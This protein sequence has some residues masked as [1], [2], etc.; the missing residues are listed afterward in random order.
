MCWTV[1]AARC[2][3]EF[4]VDTVTSPAGAHHAE[5]E[6]EMTVKVFDGLL[7]DEILFHDVSDHKMKGMTLSLYG[8]ATIV[9]K[10]NSKVVFD[11]YLGIGTY[12]YYFKVNQLGRGRERHP[13]GTEG[14]TKVPVLPNQTVRFSVPAR[15][16]SVSSPASPKFKL[17]ILFYDGGGT[18]VQ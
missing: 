7:W 9:K 8:S 15:L 3:L 2:G 5:V 14:R 12:V 11:P 10:D 4:W 18:Q 17:D 16:P 6:F 1:Q 13:S